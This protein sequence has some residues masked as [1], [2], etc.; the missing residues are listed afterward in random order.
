MN[1]LGGGSADYVNT[2]EWSAK[3]IKEAKRFGTVNIAGSSEDKKFSYIPKTLKL[4][5]GAKYVH[6]TTNNTI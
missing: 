1:L 4:T 3:A 6:V 2:G 5:P